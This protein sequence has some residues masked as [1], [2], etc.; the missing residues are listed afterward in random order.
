VDNFWLI[1]S[2][3]LWAMTLG[4]KQIFR[5]IVKLHVIQAEYGEEAKRIAR[6]FKIGKRGS[7]GYM[8]SH[9]QL[10]GK[11]PLLLVQE[12]LA[13]QG[14]KIHYTTYWGRHK[15]RESGELKI[16]GESVFEGYNINKGEK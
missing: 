4:D 9:W 16:T 11:A 6:R 1:R 5:R 7:I 8:P 3:G 13:G 10:M 2:K 15:V 12:R 14:G